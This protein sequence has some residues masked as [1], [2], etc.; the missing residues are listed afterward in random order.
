MKRILNITLIF[1]LG[2]LLLGCE[3]VK[4][5]PEKNGNPD[6]TEINTQQPETN[7]NEQASDNSD[8][9]DDPDNQENQ[10]NQEEQPENGNSGNGQNAID[11]DESSDYEFLASGAPSTMSAS[12]KAKVAKV[13][14]FALS[15]A[16]LVDEAKGGTSYVFSPVSLAYV[17]GMLSE[18]ADGTTRQ[19]IVDAL[20]FEQ[21]G[22]REIDEFCR[23]LIVLSSQESPGGEALEL[24][25]AVVI[26]QG[27][28][29]KESY[30][31]VTKNYYDAFVTEK[32]FDTEDIVGYLNS[33][34][35][36]HTHGRIEKIISELSPG[37]VAFFLNATY[38]KGSWYNQFDEYFTKSE[39]FTTSSGGK[40]KEQLMHRKD[41]DGRTAYAK[42]LGYSAVRLPYGNP[43]TGAIGNCAMTVILPDTGKSVNDILGSLEKDAWGNLQ[44]S[45]SNEYVDLKLPRFDIKFDESLNDILASL[46]ISTMFSPWADFSNMTEWDVFVSFVKQVAN[47]TVDERGTEAAAVTIAGMVGASS[48]DEQA[49]QFIQFYANRPF[50]FAITEKTTGAILFLGCYQ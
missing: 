31:E 16:G 14:E 19:E 5:G 35:A 47:I 28:G 43:E 20:G 42:G 15:F 6:N 45:F 29:L 3:K 48:P 12:D 7:N 37:A 46:G 44:S 2:L 8:N 21:G 13:N 26:S 30:K 22:Q 33:W 34:A 4:E 41:L 36:A 24:A 40:R 50:L 25:N 39:D 10:G 23:N 17:L 1:L 38:F 49:P 32:D 11:I 18:G 9:P 27:F